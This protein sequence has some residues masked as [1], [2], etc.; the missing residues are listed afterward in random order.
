[1]TRVVVA[2]VPLARLLLLP[3]PTLLEEERLEDDDAAKATAAPNDDGVAAIAEN[4]GDD[5]VM[6]DVLDEGA[7]FHPLAG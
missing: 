4:D 5:K 1:L 2:V 3:L 7:L 6:A